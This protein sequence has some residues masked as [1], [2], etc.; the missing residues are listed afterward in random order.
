MNQQAWED[1]RAQGYAHLPGFLPREICNAVLARMKID[2]NRQ[3]VSLASIE[4]EGPLLRHKAPE[5]HGY[6]YPMFTSFLW[7][8]TPS[9]EELTGEPLL[10]TYSYFRLYRQGDICRV[11]SDRPSCEHSLSLTLGYSDDLAWPLEVSSKPID[12][13][14]E[15]A[16]EDFAPD[17]PHSAI[18]MQAGDAVLYR[19]VHRAHGR[20]SPNPNRWSA[21]LFLHWVSRDGTF[22]GEAFDRQPPPS[23]V[24]F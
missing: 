23:E 22:A 21:H 13:P 24:E 15:R 18:P 3:G 1:Y 8:M 14:V 9:I 16:D 2:L 19:G 10:P 11:H 17:E 20:T 12:Q 4:R 5:L 6:H 7:G